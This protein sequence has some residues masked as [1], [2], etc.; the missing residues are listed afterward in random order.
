M[1]DSWRTP[2]KHEFTLF[3]L[4]SELGLAP[5]L[6]GAELLSAM[7]GHIL[8]EAKTLGKFVAPV[9]KPG[10]AARKTAEAGAK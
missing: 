3:A 8:A 7:E 9:H 2:H 6:S 1:G 4:D 10:H 5:G